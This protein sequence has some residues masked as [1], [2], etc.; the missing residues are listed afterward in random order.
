MF[1]HQNHEL[2]N[3]KKGQ[4]ESMNLEK[5]FKIVKLDISIFKNGEIGLIS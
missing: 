5:I 4:T 2:I 1:K 3:G